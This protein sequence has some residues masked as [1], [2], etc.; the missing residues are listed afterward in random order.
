MTFYD[1]LDGWIGD[2]LEHR[3]SVVADVLQLLAE[4]REIAAALPD[5]IV[6]P[7]LAPSVGK[8]HDLQ[9]RAHF[10]QARDRILP[11]EVRVG[12]VVADADR[13][14][15]RRDRRRR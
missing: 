6:A 12:D 15:G 13:C 11:D 7:G 4:A 3:G 9:P 10:L 2:D 5:W 1:V 8:M 14:A